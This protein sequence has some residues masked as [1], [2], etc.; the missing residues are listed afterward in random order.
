[1]LTW[2]GKRLRWGEVVNE[3][4]KIHT[5]TREGVHTKHETINKMVRVPVRI[6]F[7]LRLTR[8]VPM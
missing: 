1:M 6:E 4:F 5:D 3:I 7:C 2:L 8:C